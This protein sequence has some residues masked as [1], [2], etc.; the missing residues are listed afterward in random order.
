MRA[1]SAMKNKAAEQV[2]QPAPP[3]LGLNYF[4]RLKVQLQRELNNARVEGRSVLAEVALR[5]RC[6]AHERDG[7]AHVVELGVVKGV[8]GLQTE[9][10]TAA[11]SFRENEALEQ[12]EV[13]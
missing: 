4:P 3:R 8:E 11:A 5:I 9:L 10:Q 13:P 12:R 1:C 2:L 6:R 7:V